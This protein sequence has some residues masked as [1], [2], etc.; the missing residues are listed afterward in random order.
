MHSGTRWPLLGALRIAHA[1]L[2]PN[3]LCLRP[4]N[5]GRRTSR[6]L[7][8]HVPFLNIK[9]PRGR[10]WRVRVLEFLLEWWAFCSSIARTEIFAPKSCFSLV[11][12]SR[13]ETKSDVLKAMDFAILS[14][15]RLPI[16]ATLADRNDATERFHRYVSADRKPARCRASDVF[17]D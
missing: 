17:R 3:G 7:A 9:A 6:R 5:S 10:I 12:R 14:L 1:A 4:K 16:F 11:K 13:C 8:Q 2:L 15:A